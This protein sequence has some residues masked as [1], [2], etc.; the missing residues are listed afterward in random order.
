MGFKKT[1][2]C[3]HH[4]PLCALSE[5]HGHVLP[6]QAGRE[7]TGQGQ[8]KGN[9]PVSVVK[10]DG[11]E[12]CRTLNQQHHGRKHSCSR[13]GNAVDL[14]L[15]PSHEHVEKDGNRNDPDKQT[16]KPLNKNL[17]D[18][19]PVVGAPRVNLFGVVRP[20][21]CLVFFGH[22]E[23]P[24]TEACGP[25]GARLTSIVDSNGTP[26]NNDE[27]GHHNKKQRQRRRPTPP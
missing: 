26:D 2:R 9:R 27:Q 19:V 17:E 21:G 8:V 13:D 10:D 12:A 5:T 7:D 20:V 15:P 14:L 23:V 24:C 3:R 22:H 6:H 16:V 1:N 18:R 4:F 11:D 25:L